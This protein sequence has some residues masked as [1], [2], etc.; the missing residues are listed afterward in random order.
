VVPDD[1]LIGAFSGDEQ[2][3]FATA[4]EPYQELFQGVIRCLHS[5]LRLG[6][7][8]PGETKRIRGRIYLMKAD[9]DALR[10]R[11]ARDFPEHRP[12]RIVRKAASTAK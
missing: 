6:G 4:W 8:E 2:W 9:L 10:D 3:I 5:D 1:G 7:L 12:S 11:Y